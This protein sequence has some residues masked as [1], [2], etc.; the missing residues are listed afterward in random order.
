[1]VR[2]LASFRGEPPCLFLANKTGF[3]GILIIY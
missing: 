3:T 2:W 1:M